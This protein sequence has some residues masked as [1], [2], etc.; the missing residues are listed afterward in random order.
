MELAHYVVVYRDGPV[1]C[2]ITLPVY[3]HG[4]YEAIDYV[5]RMCPNAVIISVKKR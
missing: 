1:G 4:E 5:K 3:C 2:Y